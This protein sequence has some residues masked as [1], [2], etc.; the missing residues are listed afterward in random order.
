MQSKYIYDVLL[1][2][3]YIAFGIA[4]YFLLPFEPP[5]WCLGLLMIA[6]IFWR[7]IYISLPIIAFASA[8]LHSYFI[9]APLQEYDGKKVWVRATIKDMELTTFG[10]RFVL[11]DL[12]FWTPEE[13]KIKTNAKYIR[14]NARTKVASDLV[15]GD[16]VQ[17]AGFLSSP[18]K[19]PVISG[20]YDFAKYAYYN[21][22]GYVGFTVSEVKKLKYG[23]KKS[24]VQNIRLAIDKKILQ[25]IPDKETAGILQSFITG[26]RNLITD[27]TNDVFRKAGISHLLAISGFH[28]AMVMMFVSR[29][30]RLILC[31]MHPKYHT[32]KLASILAIILGYI[33][34]Q[35]SG[36][37]LSAE[38]AFYMTGLYFLV[39]LFNRNYSSLRSL[40][41]VACVIMLA[42]PYALISASFQMSFCAVLVLCVISDRLARYGYFLSLIISSSIISLGAGT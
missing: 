36:S 18:K 6:A 8:F 3:L 31:G 27:D 23:G 22:I 28:M 15:I 17:F 39:G 29:F 14:I 9:Y 38:R 24:Y 5:M 19:Y 42:L 40:C 12:D 10:Y 41:F 7:R 21:R 16:K 37:P 33:Y 32:K 35:I 30:F 26:R 11:E 34:L 1:A 13:K 25:V 4:V 2:P 20:G